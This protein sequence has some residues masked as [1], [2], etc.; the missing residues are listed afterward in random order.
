MNLRY[1]DLF[2]GAGGMS[3]GIKSMGGELLFSNEIDKHAVQTQKTNLDFIGEDPS[4]V[5]QSS[6]EELHEKIIGKKVEFEFQSNNVHYHKTFSNLYQNDSHLNIEQV[7]N[8]KLLK[9]VDLIVG[10]PPCQGFSNAG[11]GIKSKARSLYLDFIDDPRNQLFKYFLD[12][13][14]YYSPKAVI[15]ENVKGLASSKNYRSLIQDSLENTGLGYNTISIILNAE[16]YGIPQS[17][18]RIFFIGIR[19]D[20]KDSDLF[21]FYLPSLLIDSHSK[22][23]SLKDSISDLPSIRSNPKPLN[24]KKEDEIPI[25]EKGSFGENISCKKY[26]EL[27][28]LKNE[29]VSTIN[30]FQSKIITPKNL[31][32]HKARYNNEEDLKI[33]KLLKPG[34]SL[35]DKRNEKANE[36]NKYSTKSFG[37]KYFKLDPNKPSRTIVAHLQMDNNGYVHYGDIPRGITPREAARI[38]SFP[39][40]YKFEGPFTNQFKQIGNAVPPLLAR[41]IYTV[42]ADFLKNGISV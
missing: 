32:N 18:E 36:L 20:L 26:D 24:L 4:K 34:I 6:I 1:I 16:N 42:I 7:E 2:S 27:V 29:Y 31:Y 21:T 3:I 10:G 22:K 28:D 14:E 30:W 39:D 40:W 11:K 15:I 38:Q 13:V 19:K 37:D 9:N 5:I 8:L 23:L 25:G 41:K 12:F 33:Y 17:R 35:T